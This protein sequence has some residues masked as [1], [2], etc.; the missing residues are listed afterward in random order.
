MSSDASPAPARPVRDLLNARHSCRSFRPEPLAEEVVRDLLATAQ[1]TASWCNTQPWQVVVTSASATDEFRSVLSG[2]VRSGVA[3][4][5]DLAAPSDYLNEY[6]DRRRS[7][8]FALY[9]ALGIAREDLSARTEQ[10]LLNYEFFGA[11]HVAIVHA[12]AELGPYGWVDCGGWVANFLL[13]AAEL[14]IGAI[15][16]AAIA[17]WSNVVREHLGIGADRQIICAISF[18]HEDTTHPVNEFRTDRAPLDEVV[19]LRGF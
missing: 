8:G 5:Y 6:R 9:S 14:G 11:P 18:G 7:S 13:A 2:A 3:G 15:P 19:D 16:Q 10:M 1:R 4:Q 17:N 12:P